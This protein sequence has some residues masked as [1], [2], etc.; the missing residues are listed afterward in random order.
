MP[1]HRAWQ[2]SAVFQCISHS[3]LHI[4]SSLSDSL[5]RKAMRKGTIPPK[6]ITDFTVADFFKLIESVVMYV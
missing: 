5:S 2:K 3:I 6:L 4:A 1:I